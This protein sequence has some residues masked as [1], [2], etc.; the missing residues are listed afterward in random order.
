MSLRDRVTGPEART[1]KADSQTAWLREQLMGQLDFDS[2]RDLGPQ[3]RRAALERLLTGILARSGK[4]FTS[5]RRLTLIRQVVDEA[6]GLGVLEP[7]LEDSSIT[8]IMVNGADE[9]WVER[10]GAVQ[11]LDAS[12]STETQLYN[13]IDRI[14]N[15]VNRRVDESSPMVDARLP[16]G[17]RV[18]VVIPPLALRGPTITIRRFPRLYTMAEL[19]ALGSLDDR[20]AEL[21]G[22]CVM[23]KLNI[24]V[25][26]GTG[27]GKT[28]FLNA[29]SA[30]IPDHERI[31]TIE[32][33]AELVLQQ[34]HTVSLEGRP[35]NTEGRG[36]V[37]IRDLVRNSLRMRPD[38]IIVGEV[39]GGETL[40]M[41]QA[42]NTGH[43]GS[44]CTIHANSASQSLSRLE[45]LA[46]MSDV[47]IA[48]E[49]IHD[50]VNSAVEIIVQLSRMADGSR[51]VIEIVAMPSFGRSDFDIVPLWSPAHGLMASASQ[52]TG[53]HLE[54]LR[55]GGLD[56][57]P[58]SHEEPPG[59]PPAAQRLRA[60]PLDG[61]ADR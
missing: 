61:E 5:A 7:L 14:V 48:N 20:A 28:T 2:L 40:D 33:S 17:E 46:A 37:S 29:L 38:R 6:L 43:E 8:E 13:V 32:D 18:N 21:L 54:R 59:T 27:S 11:R 30:S 41:L 55:R 12:F 31:V 9:I 10:A 42:M 35:P 1:L 24:V 49:S 58:A 4:V 52:L 44:L 3:Q 50:Q 57:S 47:K 25:S 51:R 45:T 16:T 60:V 56:L 26:G 36:A 23:G 53:R 19:V 22:A 39:R 34:P 15:R